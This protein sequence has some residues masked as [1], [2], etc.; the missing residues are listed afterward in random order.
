MS[1][2]SKTDIMHRERVDEVESQ[3]AH[4]KI[5]LSTILA[6]FVSI[7]SGSQ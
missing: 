3:E 1:E 4:P 5:A 6:V 2:P 7:F